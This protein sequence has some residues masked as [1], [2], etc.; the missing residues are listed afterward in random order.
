MIQGTA[1]LLIDFSAAILQIIF[2]IILLSLYHN[3]FIVFEYY[4]YY[5]TL[6]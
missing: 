5:Y 4:C 6:F 2:G 3:Y 1:K